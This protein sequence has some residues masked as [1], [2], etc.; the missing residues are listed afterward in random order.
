MAD[1][2][3]DRNQSATLW[4]GRL[5]PNADEELLWEVM[6][7]AG[8]VRHIHMPRDRISG[9]HNGYAFVEF[10]TEQ[11]CEYALRVMSSLRLFGQP[12]RINKA[13]RDNAAESGAKLYV[14]NL[15]PDV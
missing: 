3:V 13:A 1:N 9:E 11:D 5:A 4:C 14:G 6:T 12:I 10:R 7:Q 2:R 15:D 8:P